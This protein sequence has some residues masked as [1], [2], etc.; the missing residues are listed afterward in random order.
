MKSRGS[1]R[2]I[3]D[4]V[5]SPQFLDDFTAMLAAAE[6]RPEAN[7]WLPK[8]HSDA[9][10]ARL[11]TFGP[12]HL[13][14]AIDWNAVSDWWLAHK[15]GANTPNWDLAAVCKFEN[16]PGLALVEAKAN[17]PEL[18]SGPKR[19]SP[20]AKDPKTNRKN[21]TAANHD[22]IREAIASA[23]RELAALDPS[24][25]LSIDSHYQLANRLAFAWKLAS[26]GLPV[27]LVYL[28]FTGDK[29]IAD[30]GEPIRDDAHWNDVFVE[31]C[32]PAVARSLFNRKLVVNITPLWFLIRSRCVL[33]QSTPRPSAH[34]ALQQTLQT[35]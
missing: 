6:A 17:V 33:N 4:W 20:K 3:L 5:E 11:E 2:H 19:L 22:R 30:A 16:R 9:T 24:V 8:G 1:R 12:L 18:S 10:E 23:S 14:D 26:L 29:G 27:V 13:R 28:G 35:R 34:T 25:N 15:R 21:R 31:H 7:K 32:R